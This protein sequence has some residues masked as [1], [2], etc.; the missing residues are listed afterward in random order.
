[1]NGDGSTGSATLIRQ[2]GPTGFFHFEGANFSFADGHVKWLKTG[3]VNKGNAVGD[4]D[5]GTFSPNGSN[6]TYCA[7]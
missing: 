5:N 7:Y 1:M 2:S 4:C 6:A 3:T